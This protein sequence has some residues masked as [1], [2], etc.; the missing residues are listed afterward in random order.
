M[1]FEDFS[2]SDDAKL[3]VQAAGYRE[4][5]PIQERAIPIL[6]QGRD[7]IGSAQ[8]GTGKTAAF[9]LPIIS[10]L[11]APPDWVPAPAGGGART[12]RPV[13]TNRPSRQV[14]TVAIAATAAAA[15]VGGATAAAAVAADPRSSRKAPFPDPARSSSSQPANWRFRSRKRSNLSQSSARCGSA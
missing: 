3:A 14:A 4:P 11:D 2:L 8:T 9:A 13:A 6:L 15:D 7:L 1:L 12:P 5:T 10:R